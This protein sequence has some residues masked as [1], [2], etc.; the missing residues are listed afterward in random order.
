MPEIHFLCFAIIISFTDLRSH[1]I[2]KWHVYPGLLSLAPWYSETVL[3]SA[4]VNLSFF[5]VLFALSGNR[6]GFGDVRLSPLIGAY[7][8]I[9]SAN[10]S[11]VL[12]ANL[13]AWITASLL[14]AGRSLIGAKNLKAEIPFAPHMFM[15][16]GLVGYFH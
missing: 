1:R 8:G 6:L 4:L 3:I 11:S 7:V 13:Y 12:I 9:W 15:G 16:A 2:R 10:V 14:I 5:I